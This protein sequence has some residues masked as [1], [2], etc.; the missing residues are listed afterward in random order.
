MIKRQADYAGT[1]IDEKWYKRY[2]K[3]SSFGRGMSDFW[4]DDNYFYIQ[5]HLSDTPVKIPLRLVKAVKTGK[6]HSG[7]FS[8]LAPF[9][10]IVWEKDGTVLSSGILVADNKF[11]V[12]L[13]KS[14]I[15]AKVKNAKQGFS[16]SA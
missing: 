2:T 15:Q 7:K 16:T 4:Y 11:K 6:W 9:I 1:E 3:D 10:K 12:E 14:E 8:P 13:V 5:R